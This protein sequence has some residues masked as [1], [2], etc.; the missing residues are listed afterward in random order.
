M[1]RSRRT[2]TACSFIAR[3]YCSISFH[4]CKKSATIDYITV[5][6]DDKKLRCL[7]EYDD[8][9]M[10]C[11]KLTEKQKEIVEKY[12]KQDKKKSFIFKLVQATR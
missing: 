10:F 3:T 4:V 2:T 5:Y 1:L 12:L 8:V 7:P 9:R 11:S 6:E